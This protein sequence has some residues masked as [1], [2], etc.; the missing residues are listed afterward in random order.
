MFR[1]CLYITI[2]QEKWVNDNLLWDMISLMEEIYSS[3]VLTIH[4]LQLIGTIPTST[5]LSSPLPS[6]NSISFSTNWN[7]VC[8][9]DGTT[10]ITKVYTVP[11]NCDIPRQMLLSNE[12]G[13]TVDY[14]QSLEHQL[15]EAKVKL[16]FITLLIY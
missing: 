16:R 2:K 5:T 10:T 15:M 6:S 14:L 13:V 11:F 12:F 7:E 1:I 9:E 8:N 3:F 4:P